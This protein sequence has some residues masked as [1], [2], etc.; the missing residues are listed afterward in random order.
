M[1]CESI[2]VLFLVHCL[3]LKHEREEAVAPPPSLEQL[4]SA[5]SQEI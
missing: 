4:R 3:A 2:V 5:T 1:K